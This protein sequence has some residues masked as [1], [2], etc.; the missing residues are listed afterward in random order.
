MKKLAIFLVAAMLL[1]LSACGTQQSNQVENETK[2]SDSEFGLVK[3]GSLTFAMTG[4]YPPLNFKK[5]GKL[6]GFDVEIG[7]EIAK[8][9]GLEANPVTNPWETIIQGLKANKYDAIIGSMT[10]TA[11]RDKQIDF[12]EPY[13]LSG[14]QIF[15]A[16]DN[17]EIQS[18]EDLQGKTIG[19]I[20]AS[21][22]K[23]MAETLTSPDMVKGYP[24]DVNAL[25]DLSLGRLD[26]VITD[27]IVGV[28]AQNE[29]GLD[30][31]P[32][33]DLLNEDRVSIGIAEGNTELANKIN[34]ALQSMIDD[35]TYEEISMKWFNTNIMEK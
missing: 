17:T 11:E 1:I 31:K 15:V 5:D 10:A 16:N 14:A 6:T 3:E 2:S 4:Q 9:M 27:K 23:D 25:Q 18:K 12:T 32:I 22:W 13:Y 20:Q 24:V 29:K 30:I 34:E 8:R 21:T 19:V 28:S 7:T 33:G 35:G 26:A